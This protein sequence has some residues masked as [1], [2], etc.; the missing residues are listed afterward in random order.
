MLHLLTSSPFISIQDLGRRGWQGLGVPVGGAMD[1]FA[2]RAANALVGNDPGAAVLEVGP[3]GVALHC[4]QEGLLALTGCGA[5][6]WLN[7][8][9]LPAWMAVRVPYG[10]LV[11]LRPI[12]PPGWSC[13]AFSGGVDVPAVLGSRSSYPRAGL[14]PATLQAGDALPL[15]K[16]ARLPLPGRWLPPTFRPAYS[17]SVLLDVIPGP[18]LERFTPGALEV[19]CAATYTVRADSDRMGCRLSGPALAHTAAAEILSQGMTVGAVQ[20][21]ASGQPIVMLADCPT[22]GGYPILAAVTGASLP[23]LAQCAA[24]LGQVRFRAVSVEQAQ[25]RWRAL[26]AGLKNGVEEPEESEL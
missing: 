26:L 6:L 2:L 18:Q 8:R 21:P 14:G 11:E 4:W 25:A 15:G 23:L 20:V 10:A 19:L 7:G 9:Q 5:E 22:T 1:G 13:L 12:G 16:P 3:G 17:D 24:A